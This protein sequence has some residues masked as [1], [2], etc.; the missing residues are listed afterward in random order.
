VQ[1]TKLE[2]VYNTNEV[3]NKIKKG[4]NETAGNIIGKR[5]KTTKK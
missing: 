4:I 5:R 1:N 3:C 2:E